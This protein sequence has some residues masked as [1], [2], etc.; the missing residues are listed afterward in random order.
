MSDDNPYATPHAE[1]VVA[2]KIPHLDKIILGQ[3][4]M[5]LSFLSLIMALVL[6]P[7]L[8]GDF[9][10][11]LAGTFLALVSSAANVTYRL[12]T[13]WIMVLL[14]CLCLCIPFINLIL[15][16]RVNAR[17]SEAISR[18]GREVGILGAKNRS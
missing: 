13:H 11:L 18:S 2:D 10:L 12:G 5:L 1:L 4:I 3:K 7:F 8:D 9:R 15:I 6:I 16:L 17:A 14:F